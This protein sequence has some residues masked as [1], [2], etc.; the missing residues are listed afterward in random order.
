MP[1]DQIAVY[2]VGALAALYL[3]HRLLKREAGGCG[4]CGGCGTAETRCATEP[5]PT[6][7]LIQIEPPPPPTPNPQ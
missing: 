5:E 4:G 6:P 3:T 1:W 2:V 7:T